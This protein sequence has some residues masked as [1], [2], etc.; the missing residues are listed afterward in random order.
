M[1][2]AASKAL[3]HPGQAYRLGAD[4][5]A[6]PDRSGLAAYLGRLG[7]GLA[8]VAKKASFGVRPADDDDDDDDDAEDMAEE[9]AAPAAQKDLNLGPP[10]K[11]KWK[12][13]P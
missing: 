9:A 6:D 2:C 7:A 4:A 12:Q 8:G 10:A 11:S 1:A 5:K 13:S 3:S